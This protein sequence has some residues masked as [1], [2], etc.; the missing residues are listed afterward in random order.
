[1]AVLR[2]RPTDRTRPTA[3]T[4]VGPSTTEW[5]DERRGCLRD[6]D[7]NDTTP[8]ATVR[9]Q[10]WVFRARPTYVRMT[11]LGGRAD[12]GGPNGPC[13]LIAG[14]MGA[15]R[16]RSIDDF[17][18]CRHWHDWSR[19]E[20]GRAVVPS[21]CRIPVDELTSWAV[22]Q[23]RHRLFDLGGRCHSPC[24][25]HRRCRYICSIRRR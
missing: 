23:H 2:R 24:R 12:G 7:V 17:E 4:T 16:W 19:W 3:A 13:S 5:D 21:H 6:V 20:R 10:R 25:R 9:W 8:T 1:M 11:P 14:M 15:W 18:R 22:W